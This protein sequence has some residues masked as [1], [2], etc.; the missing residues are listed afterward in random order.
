[1]KKCRASIATQ[2]E[3]KSQKV[4]KREAA[5]SHED[6]EIRR[7]QEEI[8]RNNFQN[9]EKKFNNH[10]KRENGHLQVRPS[11]IRHANPAKIKSEPVSY[12]LLEI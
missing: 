5:V 1:M 9:K 6:V 12:H 8:L 10:I 2:C 11:I 3:L 7:L 4:M